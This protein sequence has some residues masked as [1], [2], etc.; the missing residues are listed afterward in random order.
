MAEIGW[1]NLF[2]TARRKVFMEFSNWY[3][4]E[5]TCVLAQ[6]PGTYRGIYTLL[7]PLE[8]EVWLCTLISIT[9]VFGIYI[10]YTKLRVL[11]PVSLD[12]LILYGMSVALRESNKLTYQKNSSR[13]RY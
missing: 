4:V 10:F 12:D 6:S 8:V 7:L 13:L 2:I 1:G 9:T 5:P 3:A 11:D